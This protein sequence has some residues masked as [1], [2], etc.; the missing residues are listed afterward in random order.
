MAFRKT[1]KKKNRKQECIRALGMHQNSLLGHCIIVTVLV[2]GGVTVGVASL[3]LLRFRFTSRVIG[4]KAVLYVY[5]P[6]GGVLKGV[7]S[8]SVSGF[9]GGVSMLV[10]SERGS[11]ASESVSGFKGGV[12]MLVVSE[13]GSREV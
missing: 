5:I 9:R 3:S 2:G 11:V 13:R 4:C 7:A 1:G 6:D 8:E 12:S 10:V